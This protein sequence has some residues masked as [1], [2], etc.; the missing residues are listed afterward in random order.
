MAGF[1]QYKDKHF[2]ECF[3]LL[4]K[5]EEN[6]LGIGIL[7]DAVSDILTVNTEEVKAAPAMQG[8]TSIN[9]K[10]VSELISVDQRM[11]ILLDVERLF[12]S[13][14]TKTTI[15]DLEEAS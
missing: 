8:R 5:M 11:V 6:L 14:T 4:S 2:N 15:P 3:E 10:D 7:G 1:D 12:E 9:E 13:E